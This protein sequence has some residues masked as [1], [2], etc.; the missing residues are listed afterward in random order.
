MPD[1]QLDLGNLDH[2]Q[3]FPLVWKLWTLFFL[4]GGSFSY[5]K[6]YDFASPSKLWGFQNQAT[7]LNPVPPNYFHSFPISEYKISKKPFG[8][9]LRKNPTISQVVKEISAPSDPQW[10]APLHLPF[11]VSGGHLHSVATRV[12]KSTCLKHLNHRFLSS[13]CM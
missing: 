5:G 11:P 6:G 10:S 1:N 7:V 3:V 9:Y 13:R 4:G 8:K 2:T 12:M